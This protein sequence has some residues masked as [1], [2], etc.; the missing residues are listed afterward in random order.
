MEQQKRIL[1]CTFPICRGPQ[2]A[3]VLFRYPGS[4]SAVNRSRS[5]GPWSPEEW[6]RESRT[7]QGMSDYS[8][9][10][11]IQLWRQEHFCVPNT[12][13]TQCTMGSSFSKQELFFTLYIYLIQ[14][15]FC[16]DTIVWTLVHWH[17]GT[18]KGQSDFRP[19]LFDSR[20][21]LLCSSTTPTHHHS[22]NYTTMV[23]KGQTM[24]YS[25]NIM[26]FKKIAN[27]Q[28]TCI[29]SRQLQTV[30]TLADGVRMESDGVK[31]VSN[32]VKNVSN[33]FRKEPNGVRKVLC[34]NISWHLFT[35]HNITQQSHIWHN[36]ILTQPHEDTM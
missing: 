1:S 12:R 26:S 15:I 4:D 35:L 30:K 8:N 24:A 25:E 11:H 9:E 16:P 3:T 23:E 34:L 7:G 10:A 18:M 13:V 32:C 2:T 33:G 20:S 27:C 19:T 17:Q 5:D 28:N 29:F 6:G 21:S 36:H 14:M 31:K 22:G